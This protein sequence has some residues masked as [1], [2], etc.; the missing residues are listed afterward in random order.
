[1]DRFQDVGET[2]TPPDGD[3]RA[4][5]GVRARAVL[6]WILVPCAAFVVVSSCIGIYLNYSPVPIWDQWDGYLGF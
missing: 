1:M 4:T 5:P 2:A 6:A 3:E